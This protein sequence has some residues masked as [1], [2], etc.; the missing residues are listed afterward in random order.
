[1]KL[2]SIV[3]TGTG[4]LGGSVFSVRN[5]A[6]VV[7]TYQPIVA[8]PQSEQQIAQRAKL[9]LASQLSAA[10]ANEVA[11]FGRDGMRSPRNLF[12]KDLFARNVV[13]YEND[14]AEISLTDVRLTSSRV[15]MLSVNTVTHADGQLS[16]SGN[17]RSDFVDQV[18]S[19]RVVLVTSSGGTSEPII[20]ETGNATLSGTDVFTF[21]SP[22]PDAYSVVMYLYAIVPSSEAM[23]ARYGGMTMNDDNAVLLMAS[24]NDNPS[25]FRYSITY[26]SNVAAVE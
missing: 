1:M 9:K 18:I 13:T 5:G 4:K 26:V 22:L 14:T 20:T 21:T 15:D 3:G 24:V 11:P 17:I 10:F 23:I 6:Q 8:N 7:R 25:G 12:V 19:I 2:T 16:V